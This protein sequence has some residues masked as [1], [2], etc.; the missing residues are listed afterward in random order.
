MVIPNPSSLSLGQSAILPKI[1]EY[2][3]SHGRSEDF[4]KQFND[5]YCLGI[6]LLWAS[7]RIL[8]T[9]PSTTAFRYDKDWFNH[10][11]NLIINLKEPVEDGELIRALEI[12]PY[13]EAMERLDA[14]DREDESFLGLARTARLRERLYNNQQIETFIALIKYFQDKQ[15]AGMYWSA[16]E[17]KKGVEYIEYTR[18]MS[19]EKP[20]EKKA[21]AVVPSE[22]QKKDKEKATVSSS[23]KIIE[24]LIFTS[25]P[26]RSQSAELLAVQDFISRGKPIVIESYNHATVIFEDVDGKIYYFD[27]NSKVGEIE[28][29]A[30]PD[31]GKTVYSL[32]AKYIFIS[33]FKVEGSPASGHWRVYPNK[34]SALTFRRLVDFSTMSSKAELKAI[35]ILLDEKREHHVLTTAEPEYYG[36]F[37][38]LH[39]AAKVGDLD[40]VRYCLEKRSSVNAPDDEGWTALMLASQFGHLTVV[41]ELVRNGADLDLQNIDGNTALICAVE[42]KQFEIALELLTRGANLSVQNILGNTPLMYAIYNEDMKTVKFLLDAGANPNLQNSNGDAALDLAVKSKQTE[43]AILLMQ[44]QDV[45]YG[46]GLF[47]WEG[48]QKAGYIIKL[49]KQHKFDEVQKE[50]V[51]LEKIA[52]KMRGKIREF[53]DEE[54]TLPNPPKLL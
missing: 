45:L 24:E 11:E 19:E 7:T 50:I 25:A 32:L 42:C 34:Q 33:N 27:P 26:T 44:N 21:E 37:S 38:I 41:N 10:V 53:D 17:I 1:Q 8:S 22:E 54:G 3:R 43:I 6:S 23:G 13:K 29:V 14:M 35:K 20:A 48:A 12:L 31:S 9:K 46:L 47:N 4:V 16:K 39:Q 5:G 30:A 15:E 2:L 51:A 36:G 49:L 18:M 40:A 52:A 28:I